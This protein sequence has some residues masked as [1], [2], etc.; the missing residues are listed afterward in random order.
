[1]SRR[2]RQRHN[3]R[4]PMA[5]AALAEAPIAMV[6]RRVAWISPTHLEKQRG[7]LQT[8]LL[9]F[10]QGLHCPTHWRSLADASKVAETLCGFGDGGGPD[11]LERIQEGQQVLHAVH[12]RH[13]TRGS[14][15]LYPAELEALHTMLDMHNIQLENSTYGDVAQ[16]IDTTQRRLAQ[17]LAGNAPA[18]AIIVVGDLEGSHAA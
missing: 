11:V 7:I 8:A 13:Q 1:M 5:G 2:A 9:E 15:T 6:M 10:S 14:W 16:A 12:L 17:A 3:K 18:N 4:A